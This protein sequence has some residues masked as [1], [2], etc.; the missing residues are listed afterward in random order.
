METESLEQIKLLDQQKTDANPHWTSH[1]A[2]LLFRRYST[3]VIRCAVMRPRFPRFRCT[4]PLPKTNP[5]IHTRRFLARKF[6]D[7]GTH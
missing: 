3:I 5:V 6:M 2:V 4:A 1:R 7:G